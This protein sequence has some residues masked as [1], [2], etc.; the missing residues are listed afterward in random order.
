MKA[1]VIPEWPYKPDSPLRDKMVEVFKEFYG[2]EPL[3]AGLQHAF[4]DCAVFAAKM[5]D[6][7]M[8]S[9]GPD[10]IN[11]HTPSERMSLPSYDRVYAYLVKLLERL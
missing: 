10:I 2:K 5:P 7:D 6:A 1:A 3:I 9:I 4:V 8:A 11:I